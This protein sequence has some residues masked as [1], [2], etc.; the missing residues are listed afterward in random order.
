MNL[1][2]ISAKF[3]RGCS[4]WKCSSLPIRYQ[5]L[6]TNYSTKDPAK[7]IRTLFKSNARLARKLVVDSPIRAF[8]AF[9]ILL[10]LRL[11][12]FDPLFADLCSDI[13]AIALG[14]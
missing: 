4:H 5:H 10:N 11:L 7:T 2:K 9:R 12:S 13:T 6:Q 1:G 8:R 3:L 14:D